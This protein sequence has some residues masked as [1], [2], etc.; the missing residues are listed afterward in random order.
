MLPRAGA[1][2][3]HT[4]AYGPCPAVPSGPAK[5]VP[6]REASGTTG[7]SSLPGPRPSRDCSPAIIWGQ[8]PPAPLSPSPGK[9]RAACAGPRA[10][11]LPGEEARSAP[12]SVAPAPGLSEPSRGWFLCRQ[13]RDN[14]WSCFSPCFFYL[15]FLSW[16]G[17][18]ERGIENLLGSSSI[19]RRDSPRVVP[20]P[21]CWLAG[22]PCTC[23]GSSRSRA[24]CWPMVDGT[25]RAIPLVSPCPF[26]TPKPR[27]A[28]LARA[29]SRGLTPLP[30]PVHSRYPLRRFVLYIEINFYT[31]SAR[32][33]CPA[34]PGSEAWGLPWLLQGSG[35][36]TPFGGS[37]GDLGAGAEAQAWG[38][39]LRAGPGL[40]GTWGHR[41]REGRSWCRSGRVSGVVGGLAV[42]VPWG[43]VAPRARPRTGF[44][45]PPFPAA[46]CPPHARSS[47]GSATCPPAPVSRWQL[48]PRLFLS[49]QAQPRALGAGGA[50]TSLFPS[51]SPGALLPSAGV[52]LWAAGVGE[53]TPT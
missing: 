41:E 5:A 29:M 33:L 1:S 34:S 46:S 49:L 36:P 14:G 24:R 20:G 47:R 42:P 7:S 19:S 22:G 21:Q 13:Q 35:L 25:A 3:C 39:T 40:F 52:S 10:P 2:R 8:S 27:R 53:E 26:S 17:A 31:L 6:V 45:P 30:A 38:T 16:A 48:F 28:L 37:Y 15:N 9:A 4:P 50:G 32:A 18:S 44:G 12:G 43:A 23:Q 51:T 11:V